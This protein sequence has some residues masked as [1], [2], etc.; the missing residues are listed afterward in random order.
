[1]VITVVE[2]NIDQIRALGRAF[3]V[4]RLEVF[5]SACTSEYEPGR[6]DV[7]FLVEY[8]QGYDF[9]PWLARVQELDEALSALLG[10]EVDLVTASALGN[11][12]FRSEVEKTR[13]VIYDASEVAEV[14]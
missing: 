4:T 13:K 6:S 2:K 10:L 3:G 11:T 9:G 7:D 12:W 5:G 8:P 1:M 14:A